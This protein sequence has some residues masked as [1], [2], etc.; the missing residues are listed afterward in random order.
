[1]RAEV[2]EP[3]V[4]RDGGEAADDQHAERAGGGVGFFAAEF[5]REEIAEEVGCQGGDEGEE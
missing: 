4:A 1:M 2:E 5:L 3:A